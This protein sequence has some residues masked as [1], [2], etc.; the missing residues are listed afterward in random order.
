MLLDRRLDLW[1]KIEHNQMVGM[2]R[3]DSLVGF[4]DE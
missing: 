3:H 1:W 2:E 4:E